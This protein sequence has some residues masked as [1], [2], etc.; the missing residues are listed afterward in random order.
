M[1]NLG[2]EKTNLSFVFNKNGLKPR[3]LGLKKDCTSQ[4]SNPGPQHWNLENRPVGFQCRFSYFSLYNM[5]KGAISF[6]MVPSKIFS[7]TGKVV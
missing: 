1:G 6:R 4:D 5:I 3:F 7:D 2:S